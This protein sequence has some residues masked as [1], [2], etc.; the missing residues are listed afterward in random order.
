[1]K[2]I[3][4][5]IGCAL[6]LCGMTALTGCGSEPSAP[7]ASEVV[8]SEA[9]SE[10]TSSEA[11]SSAAGESTSAQ[12]TLELGDQLKKPEIGEEIA[13]V[14]QRRV[15]LKCGCFHKQH[16]RRWKTLSSLQKAV[17]M[18]DW[19]STASLTAL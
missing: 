9:V 18:T 10:T 13:V 7:P 11:I 4:I 8:S 1:M 16:Q 5:G 2:K 6:L 17:F 15:R 19:T 14:K 3:G 12:T